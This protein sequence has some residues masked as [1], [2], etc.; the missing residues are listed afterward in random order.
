[1]KA[2]P[3][4]LSI[5]L[6]ISVS[7][8]GAA[9]R[10]GPPPP[11]VPPSAQ[12]HVP[13]PLSVPPPPSSIPP[14]P[15]ALT[16]PMP[17]GPPRGTIDLYQRP[18]NFHSNPP[19]PPASL[20][21]PGSGFVPGYW[22]GPYPP[23]P[24]WPGP[25]G[26]GAYMTDSSPAAAAMFARSLNGMFAEAKGGLRFETS[27]GF[28]QVI[29]DGNYVGIVEDFGPRG[30]PLELAVGP[31][32]VELRA[33]D[34]GAVTFDVNIAPNQISRYRGDL[35]APVTPPP[36]PPSAANAPAASQK[37]YVIPNCYAGNRPPAQPLPSGCSIAQM[38]VIAN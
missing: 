2:G 36:A 5:P 13:P 7:T 1:M 34:Y 31:H 11:R 25:Y 30:R 18:D 37:Y 23:G 27:P 9:Q 16:V 17:F 26:P 10:H 6:L 38:R 20:F 29:V 8:T 28:A 12:Q 14:A 22:P 33:T 35:Q 15:A 24:Y 21:F 4:F 19:Q 3:L 32:H